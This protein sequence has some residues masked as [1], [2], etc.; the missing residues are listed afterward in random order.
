MNFKTFLLITFI[1]LNFSLFSQVDSKTEPKPEFKVKGKAIAR[2]FANYNSNLGG[3]EQTAPKEAMQ[4][5]RAYLGYKANISENFSVKVI[6]DVGNTNGKYSTYLKTAALTYKKNK[7]SYNIGMIATKQFKTQ[8]KFWGYRYLRKT[9]QD[10]YKYNASADLGFS[11]DYKVID[12]LSIDGIIQNGGGYKN[13]DPTGT[14]RGGVGTTIS[15]YKPLTFRVYYDISVKPDIEQQ[16]I[17]TFLGYRF[18]KKLRIAAEYNY[19]LNNKFTEDHNMFGYSAYATYSINPKFDIFARYDNSQSNITK[20]SGDNPAIPSL[21]WNIDKDENVTILGFQ[22][23]PIS[24]VKLSVNFRRV[25]SAIVDMDAVNWMF[26]N[27]EFK[28]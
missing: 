27:L 14:Y 16:S 15:I 23:K 17:A 19:Q 3:T 22:Y 13:V 1:G 4:I 10:Q 24:R 18:G 25:Q 21:A 5:K 2:V 28:L 6:F 11:V 8:E 7:F 12:G 20:L 9:F 26:L